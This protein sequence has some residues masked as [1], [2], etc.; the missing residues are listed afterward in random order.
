MAYTPPP[1]VG[2]PAWGAPLND[3]I[4]D[5]ASNG[6]MPQDQSFINWMGDPLSNA[7][8]TLSMTS[9]RV[10]LTRIQIR[11]PETL[12]GIATI[13]DTGGTGITSARAGMYDAAGNRVART[14]SLVT[15]WATT[16][17]CGLTP[18]EA[19]FMASEG[20]YFMAFS[21]DSATPTVLRGSAAPGS[22]PS[23][24]NLNTGVNQFRAAFSPV[25]GGGLPASLDLGTCTAHNVVGWGA[26]Y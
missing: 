23:P 12:T 16:N 24:I 7:E 4:G 20:L 5:I 21:V 1:V 18:F 13:V 2:Q 22:S 19:S 10:Y 14:A 25:I 6:F 17:F 26:I 11:R 15:Q 8:D 3:T 9:G